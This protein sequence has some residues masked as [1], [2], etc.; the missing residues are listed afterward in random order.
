MGQAEGCTEAEVGCCVWRPRGPWEGGHHHE[1]R[2]S[3]GCSCWAF[4]GT[5]RCCPHPDFGHLAPGSCVRHL[6]CALGNPSGCAPYCP[7]PL[8]AGGSWPGPA[9]E[10]GWA[11]YDRSLDQVV[12]LCTCLVIITV[13][14]AKRFGGVGVPPTTPP[15]VCVPVIC[16]WPACAPGV[17]GGSRW[18]PVARA[19]LQAPPA[20]SAHPRPAFL[21]LWSQAEMSVSLA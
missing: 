2:P 1:L 10:G 5:P 16:L 9:L 3:D 13:Q 17:A 15:F 4:Q 12:P 18:R 20:R 6:V 14:P 11:K 21:P 19:G 7:P 8:A